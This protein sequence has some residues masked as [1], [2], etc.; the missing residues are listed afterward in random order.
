MQKIYL[1]TWC[2]RVE[3]SAS[4]LLGAAATFSFACRE[5][6]PIYENVFACL[7]NIVISSSVYRP[8]FTT[9]KRALSLHVFFPNPLPIHT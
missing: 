2:V 8:A 9:H 1:K 5:N 7:Q 6:E 4:G 3:G